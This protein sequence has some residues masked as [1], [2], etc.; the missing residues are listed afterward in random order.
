MADPVIQPV[1]DPD[2]P[3]VQ[4]ALLDFYIAVAQN[5]GFWVPWLEHRLTDYGRMTHSLEEQRAARDMQ[6]ALAR[7]ARIGR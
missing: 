6:D 1:V 7:L 3:E 2:R 4:A 5:Q